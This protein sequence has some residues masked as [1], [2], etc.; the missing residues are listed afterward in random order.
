M[1]MGLRFSSA[2]AEG[3]RLRSELTYTN[4]NTTLDNKH[5][6][7]TS[8]SEFSLTEQQYNLDFSK[9][10][11][12]YLNISGGTFYELNSSTSTTQDTKTHGDEKIL[13]PFAEISLDN[14]QYKTGFGYRK[15]QIENSLTGITTTTNTRDEYN[16][17]LGWHPAADLPE[18]NLRYNNTHTYND[19]ETID[20]I[21]KTLNVDTDYTIGKDVR[22]SYLYTRVDKENDI[23]GSGTLENNHN[24][25]IDYSHSFLNNRLAMSTG[26]RIRHNTFE[27]DA[28]ETAEVPLLRSAGLALIDV[29]PEDE[30]LDPSPELI[31]GNTAASAGLNIG[32][33]GDETELTAIGIDF[34]F[35]VSVET[36]HVWVDRHLPLSI[37]SAYSWSIYTSPDNN[38]GATWTLLT[39]LPSVVFG[40]LDNRFE[41]P[42]PKTTARFF[43]VTVR[44]LSP[45]I[46]DA[47]VFPDIFITEMQA[48]A[49]SSGLTGKDELTRVNHN[50]NLNLGYR[51]SDRT[52]FG[53]NM[54]YDVL[55]QD[56]FSNKRTD[57]T[58]GVYYNHMFNRIFSSSTNVSRTERNE[59]DDQSPSEK[60]TDYNYSSSLRA[61]YLDTLKQVLSFSGSRLK[62]EDGSSN[63]DAFYLRTTALLYKG[64]SA[65]FDTGYSWES[66]LN[67]S[68][69]SSTIVKTGANLIPNRKITVNLDY[70]QTQTQYDDA[71][72]DQT[73]ES[74]WNMQTLIAPYRALTFN[75]RISVTEDEDSKHTLQNYSVNWAPFPDG[76]LQ[77]FFSYTETLRPEDGQKEKS[78]GPSLKWTIGPHLTLDMLYNVFETENRFQTTDSDT[79]R[80]N[81]RLI[82]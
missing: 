39:T 55:E 19:P 17:I 27:S 54:F 58:S 8:S 10:I 42:I 49:T 20:R 40:T 59:T 22:I 43:M 26:Y 82:F 63:R 12:P 9:R 25:K 35:P 45:A 69:S 52:S 48:F 16:T 21:E 68:D 13:R 72:K 18:I 78:L 76:N 7:Q 3:V 65:F 15:T 50:Y 31:D 5:T 36:I 73:T 47:A 61:S 56:P 23:S 38:P 37:S 57:L 79:F 1:M 32:L 75:I 81:L 24:G 14:P 71:E 28:L 64:F 4:S 2:F 11:Y 6:G 51:L 67:E 44:P 74:S 70:S 60:E 30:S 29:S 62:E 80:T 66:P 33:S 41:L 53:C 46:V 34:G 77:L